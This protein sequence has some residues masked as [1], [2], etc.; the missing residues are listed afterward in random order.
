MPLAACRRAVAVLKLL[1]ALFSFL[2]SVRLVSVSFLFSFRFRLVFDSFSD[3]SHFVFVF[4][5]RFVFVSY[6]GGTCNSQ[7]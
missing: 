5:F 4:F 1:P 2:F 6:L 3:R 7:R